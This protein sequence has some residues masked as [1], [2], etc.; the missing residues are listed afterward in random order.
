MTKLVNGGIYILKNEAEPIQINKY[1]GK[2]KYHKGYCEKDE[3]GIDHVGCRI[4][5][6][7]EDDVVRQIWRDKN[8]HEF[9]VGDVV[10]KLTESWNS[11]VGHELGRVIKID[12]L[13]PTVEFENSTIKV[14]GCDL[15]IITPS[16]WNEYYS[17]LNE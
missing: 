14:W 5:E 16:K 13:K 7:T 6:V 15:L 1:D 8:G 17:Y 9:E 12:G 11:K 2:F 10:V 4:Y 3:K